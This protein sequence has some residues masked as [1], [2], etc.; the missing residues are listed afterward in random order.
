MKKK[1]I[2]CIGNSK[3]FSGFYSQIAALDSTVRLVVVG[4][5]RR[6]FFYKLKRAVRKKDYG[7]LKVVYECIEP[8]KL[9]KICAWNQAELEDIALSTKWYDEA[10]AINIL[11]EELLGYTQYLTQKY[12]PSTFMIFGDKLGRPFRYYASETGIPCINVELGYFRPD[13]LQVDMKGLN[14]ECSI[15]KNIEFYQKY[16][17]RRYDVLPKNQNKENIIFLPFQMESDTQIFRNSPRFKKMAD[18]LEAV[19]DA[20]KVINAGKKETIKVVFK[21]HPLQ[22][23][24]DY[25]NR[26]LVDDVVEKF[27][28][29]EEAPKNES[30]ENLIDKARLVSVINST[31]GFE[32]LMRQTPVIVFGQAFYDVNGLVIKVGRDGPIKPRLEQALDIKLDQILLENFFGY[33]RYCHHKASPI[34]EKTDPDLG[35]IFEFICQHI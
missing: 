26:Q 27:S 6:G 22:H 3:L 1:T 12:N 24:D 19:A 28:C 35:D 25:Y 7:Q 9:N 20:V 8:G 21:E 2:L 30:T 18:Y 29:V 5:S 14:A 33:V 31:V 32:A 10:K 11:P 13:T 17:G 15:P 34:Y 4:F 16:N 23:E